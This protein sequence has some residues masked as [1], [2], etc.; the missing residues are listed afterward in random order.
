MQIKR[1]DDSLVLAISVVNI[2]SYILQKRI[3]D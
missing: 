1:N 2:K 3:S